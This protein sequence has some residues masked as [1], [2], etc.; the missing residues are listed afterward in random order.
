MARPAASDAARMNQPGTAKG[1]WQ[2]RLAALP[3]RDAGRRL[4]A[5]SEAAGRAI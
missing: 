3:G 5:A 2:W 1:A 4:R